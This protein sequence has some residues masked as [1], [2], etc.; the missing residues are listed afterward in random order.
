MAGQI[1][2]HEVVKVVRNTVL[3]AEK[4]KKKKRV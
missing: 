2:S 1:L 4:I 3:I